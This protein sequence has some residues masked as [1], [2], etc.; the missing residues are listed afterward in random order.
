MLRKVFR[1]IRA[2]VLCFC[3]VVVLLSVLF[4]YA[5]KVEPYRLKT[6]SLTL[7]AGLSQALKVVQV[8]DIQIS[9]HFTTENLHKVVRKINEQS[10]D[11]VLV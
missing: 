9:E 5:T 3:L 10:P 7:Q 1:I 2:I 8:S 6:E 11:I 4:V